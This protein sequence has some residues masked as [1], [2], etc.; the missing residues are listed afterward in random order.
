MK[1]LKQL[2]NAF[3]P[4]GYEDDIRKI[5]KEYIKTHLDLNPVIDNLGSL[6]FTR[7]GKDGSPSIML[8]AHMDEVGLMVVGYTATGHLKFVGAG[9]LDPRVLPGKSVYIGKDQMPGVIG[10]KPPHLE[11]REKQSER[12]RTYPINELMIDIG[13]KDKNEAERLAPL[14][15]TAMFD[16][17]FEDW[18]T[19]IKGKS[20]DDRL[21]CWATA[22][23][24][25]ELE[26]DCTLIAS[27]TMGE[28]IGMKGARLA[29]RT[30]KPD[31]VV[32]LEGTSAGDMPGVDE[33]MLCT[34]M[35][36]GPVITFEDR[37]I[38][39]PRDLRHALEE[40]ANMN[41]INYQHKGTVTGGTNAGVMQTENGGT[42]CLVI[43]VGCRYIHS[44]VSL[45]SKSDAGD[46]IT[47]VKSFIKR[48][49]RG[50]I[51]I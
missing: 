10:V 42:K 33:H 3:G 31:L 47:L 4:P 37:S 43:A 32:A 49:D 12:E 45:A 14:N 25:C 50:E 46:M 21:G 9:G 44:P 5:I 35:G 41:N 26:T 11:R 38:I 34:T 51:E 17:V 22:K 40:T 29:V 27:F 20:F 2:S 30:H 19:T 16:T 7:K 1:L 13:A 28:E 24:F 8:D 36:A 15:T 39:I 6:S 18:G 48:I 23:V